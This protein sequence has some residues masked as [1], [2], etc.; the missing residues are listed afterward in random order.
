MSKRTKEEIEK[1]LYLYDLCDALF[2]DNLSDERLSG[3]LEK[4]DTNC[5]H[6]FGF[7]YRHENSDSLAF[8]CQKCGFIDIMAWPDRCKKL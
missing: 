8:K 7:G 3:N 1:A 5:E 2:T 4:N 6:L